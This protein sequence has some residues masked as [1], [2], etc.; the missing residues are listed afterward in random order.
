VQHPRLGHAC[1]PI[2]AIGWQ[3]KGLIVAWTADDCRLA[4]AAGALVPQGLIMEHAALIVELVS[5]GFFGWLIH[6]Y[7][8]N[9]LSAVAAWFVVSLVGILQMCLA[10]TFDVLESLIIVGLILMFFSFLM[11]L[12]VGASESRE[13]WAKEDRLLK[14]VHDALK[15][16]E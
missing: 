15:P 9:K 8:Q 14:K 6:K 1:V 5:F 13:R 4:L 2:L 11:I 16:F 3:K 12:V 7:L 10:A